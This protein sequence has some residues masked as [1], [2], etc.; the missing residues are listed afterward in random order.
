MSVLGLEHGSLEEQPVLLVTEPFLQSLPLIL[1]WGLASVEH[2][3]SVVPSPSI[4]KRTTDDGV[5]R[6]S[7][8]GLDF[9]PQS[10]CSVQDLYSFVCLHALTLVCAGVYC[11]CRSTSVEVPLHG[12]Q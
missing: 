2:L 11:A 10:Q 1:G 6:A 7:P 3:L 4:A 8:I 9:S 12:F 5:T